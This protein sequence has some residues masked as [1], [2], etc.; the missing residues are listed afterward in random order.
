MASNPENKMISSPQRLLPKI[1]FFSC[2]FLLCSCNGD[3]TKTKSVDSIVAKTNDSSLIVVKNTS[4]SDPRLTYINPDTVGKRTLYFTFDDGP[5]PGTHVVMSIIAHEK[6]PA[7]FFQIGN[8]IRNSP[9]GRKL[10]PQMR[11]L[12]NVVLCNHSD[13]HAFDNHYE[14]FYKDSA[15]AVKD[16]ER[17]RDS[18]HFLNNVV[19]TPGN[20]I[21]RTPGFDQTTYARYKKTANAIASAGFTIVGWDT[22]WRHRKLILKE[23]VDQM[24][25]EIT[26]MYDQHENKAPNHCVLLTHDLTFLDPVDS[27]KLVELIERFKANPLY[28]FDVV[29]NHPLLK[30]KKSDP[31]HQIQTKQ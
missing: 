11:L 16:F 26:D 4:I 6:I 19:R 30:K 21:W 23:S 20:N 8:N 15:G 27:S 18:S 10:E 14:R 2:M 3:A 25:K 7:T 29:T 24:E 12:P 1:A 28:R 13:T 5:N 17:C 31:I 9:L 22:E